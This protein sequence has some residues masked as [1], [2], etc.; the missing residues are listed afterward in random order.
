LPLILSL[1]L[2]SMFGP[3][4]E[5]V[6]RKLVHPSKSYDKSTSKSN[7]LIIG[8]QTKGAHPI[9]LWQSARAYVTSW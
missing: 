4:P 9:P 6:H 7:L 3:P 8:K 5:E 2:T 1:A